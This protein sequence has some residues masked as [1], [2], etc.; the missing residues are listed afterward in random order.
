MSLEPAL[1]PCPDCHHKVSRQAETCPQCGR[2]F[3]R[4][5]SE[6]QIASRVFVNPG[7]GWSW[8][9]MWGIIFAAILPT[10]VMFL[11]FIL[12][13]GGVASSLPATNR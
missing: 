6:V 2:F 9:V 13:L 3:Q 7:S 4:F 5:K 11:L 8:V 1:V 12:F 10:I